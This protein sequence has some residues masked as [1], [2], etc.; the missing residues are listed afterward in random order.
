MLQTTYGV[1]LAT[2]LGYADP[3]VAQAHL[4]AYELSQEITDP[5]LLFPILCGL[6]GFFIVR[7]DLSRAMVLADHLLA[8]E[9]QSPNTTAPALAYGIHGQTSLLS[10]KLLAARIS[11]AQSLTHYTADQHG[12]LLAQYNEDPGVISHTLHAQALW[13]LGY[14]DQAP[15]QL[16]AGEA[17]AHELAHP[18]S[19]AQHLCNAMTVWQWRG[20][21]SRVI[22]C[23][24][25]LQAIC[26]AEAFPVWLAG[27]MI[28]QGW[29]LVQQGQN[30]AGV[31]LMQQGI[32]AW[33]T[34]GICLVLP[35]YQTLLAEA[36]GAIG[37]ADKGVQVLDEVLAHINATQ[38]RFYEAELWRIKGML[39]IQSQTSPGQ[40][41][42]SQDNSEETGPRSLTPDPQ[43]QA[44][45][46]F[47]K[48]IEVARQQQAKSLELRA[49]M[50]LVRLCQQHGTA[51]PSH[52]TP[53]EAHRM[54][55]EIYNWFTEGF[56]TKDLQEAKALLEN[57]GETAKRDN[58]EKENQE[59]S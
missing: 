53:A 55:V 4:R 57:L 50:S 47:L 10:G 30:E 12:R 2:T 58:G 40:V 8:L 37:Q 14:A 27:G 48:A 36:Y 21:V 17:L 25:E 7:S 44:E 33:Q 52:T 35:Y 31:T 22:A 13:L 32:R 23:Y 38:E 19:F 3:A 43:D 24:E 1:T 39:L 42:T 26:Q 49:V 45:A 18:Y 16:A 56:E 5:A 46:C 11:F 51:H 6:W 15:R 34:I 41:K 9:D 20:E 29:A 59:I 54:L 28:V